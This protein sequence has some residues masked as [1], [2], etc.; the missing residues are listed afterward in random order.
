MFEILLTR[1]I[2]AGVR[3]RNDEILIGRSM[4]VNFYH[5]DGFRKDWRRHPGC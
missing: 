3:G 1:G 4:P 2:F 5:Y